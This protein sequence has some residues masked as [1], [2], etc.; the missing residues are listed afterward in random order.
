MKNIFFALSVAS[1]LLFVGCKKDVQ[2][3][4]FEFN[5]IAERPTS[6]DGA[7]THLVNEQYVYWDEGDIISLASEFDNGKDVARATLIRRTGGSDFNG[8]FQAELNENASQF[9]ALYPYNEDNEINYSGG[10]FSNVKIMFPKEQRFTNDNTF[11]VDACPMVAYNVTGEYPYKLLFHNLCGFVRIQIFSSI[12][13]KQINSI[14]FT[15]TSLTPKQIS[16]LFK[17]ENYMAFDPYLVPTDATGPNLSCNIPVS[18]TVGNGTSGL[19]TCYLALPALQPDPANNG[20]TTYTITMTVR[21]TANQQCKKVFS[22]P[23]RRNGITMMPAL[24]IT[25]W[26]ETGSGSADASI[27]GIGTQDRPFKIYTAQELL[28]VR[29]AI[30]LNS[31]INSKTITSNTYFKIMRSDIVLNNT[32]DPF[33]PND[34]AWTEGIKNF[35]G[36]FFYGASN[37][38][39]PGITNN[40][41]HPLFESITEN[42]VVQGITIKGTMERTTTE[43]FDFSPLCYT[44]RGAIIDCII[45]E[46]ARFSVTSTNSG[47]C[48]VAGICRDNY[49]SITGCGCKGALYASNHAVAGIVLHNRGS[50]S[51]CYISSPMMAING[52]LY[53]GGICYENTSSGSITDC[54]FAANISTSNA[55]W[56]GIAY[57][58]AG[59]ISRCFVDHSGILHTDKSVGGIV[60]VNTAGSIDYCYNQTDLMYGGQAGMT[61]GGLGGIV[62][63][64]EGG[65]IRNSYCNIPTVSFTLTS[66]YGGGFVADMSGG[67]IKNCYSYLDLHNDGGTAVGSFA[68]RITGGEIV[69]CYG[70]EV[71]DGG[72]AFY[73]IG[74]D[75]YISHSYV[76]LASAAK[77][78]SA[79]NARKEEAA[80]TP[81]AATSGAF[82][83]LATNLNS[84]VSSNGSPYRSWVQTNYAIPTISSTAPASSKSRSSRRH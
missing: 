32:D 6:D 19:L 13:P 58:N 79:R 43:V 72:R 63:R 64:M 73:G 41:N 3:S 52:T 9:V 68:G 70:Y 76:Y 10:S 28:Q 66:G 20:A 77:R 29:D 42:G 57:S 49:G 69:N 82:A 37:S 78:N 14:S 54:Y 53:A 81:F 75:S 48:G 44:N 12:D 50:L 36:H 7:K 67:A 15:E 8:L 5:A 45:A 4:A 27:A 83:T 60:N 47:T 24:D 62:N 80:I 34:V 71:L 55:N 65:E 18:F 31:T 1:L 16:G 46:S 33:D 11:G 23:I 61:G 2:K 35:Q 38:S 17:V 59:S 22:V 21:N 51:A 26:S 74:N 25:M 30:N 56:G 84:W 39:T 40:S